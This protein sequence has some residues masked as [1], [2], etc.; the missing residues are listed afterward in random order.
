MNVRTGCTT[1]IAAGALIMLAGCGGTT[2][3][4]P[5]AGSPA[6]SAAP[7]PASPMTSMS[8]PM[9]SPSS[10]AT[11][12]SAQSAPVV[13]TIKSFAYEGPEMVKP[14]ATVTVKN[15]DTVA[16]TVTSDTGNA[17]DVKVGPSSSATFTAPSK[18]G[19]FAYHC[20]YHASMHGTLTV[21][22]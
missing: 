19:S 4:S 17:F 7:M 3:P 12:S 21:Q 13:I 9:M 8:S 15:E 11:P 1:L 14:G 18:A 6:A 22:S 20:T 5:G 10:S 16:H 2:A